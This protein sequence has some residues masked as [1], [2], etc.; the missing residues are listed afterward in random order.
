MFSQF[1]FAQA[2]WLWGLFA[3]PAVFLLYALF[4]RRLAS[5]ALLARFADPHLL[6]HLLKK[7][8]APVRNSWV[9]L[10]LWAAA[11]LCGMLAM[12]GPRWNYTEQKTFSVS[13]NL[14]IVLDLAQSMNAQDVKPSVSGGHARK[15]KTCW[16]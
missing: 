3:I 11:W 7:Q 13:Q 14:V 12:A 9:L 16:T 5:A 15:S 1:Q 10:S 6:A 2:A 8:N 4:Y